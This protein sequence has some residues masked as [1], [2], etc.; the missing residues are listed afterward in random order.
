[1]EYIYLIRNLLQKG[2]FMTT[3]DLKDAGLH[4]PIREECQKYLRLAIQ[5]RDKIYNFQCRAL[6]FGLLSSP[7]V[8][9]QVIA[10]A[11]VPLRLQSITVIS[12]L[13]D[14]RLM[15]NSKEV[16]LRKLD[17]IQ[18]SLKHLGWII[19]QEKSNPIPAQTIL[20]LVYTIISRE[21]KMVLSEEKITCLKQ[22]MSCLQ[23]NH[24]C[25]VREVMSAL[26][27]MM[28]SIPAV[29]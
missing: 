1:M 6:P 17:T 3:L 18:Q 29:Q 27:L 4:I 22:K 19:N 20:F 21:Q 26:G 12:F 25:K 2:V 23:S 10:E 28:A 15:V 7:R 14:L 24:S 9:T 5:I 16:L 8:F 13:D 11:L